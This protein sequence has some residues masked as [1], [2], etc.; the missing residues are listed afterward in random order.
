L[1]F[2]KVPVRINAAKN[3]TPAIRN[4]T[5]SPEGKRA[6]LVEPKEK[7]SAK[8]SPGRADFTN[9]ELGRKNQPAALEHKPEITT[10]AKPATSTS[11]HAL[12]R[13]RNAKS[14]ATIATMNM[15]SY[16]A[17]V[18]SAAKISSAVA[19]FPSGFSLSSIEAK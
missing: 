2:H 4:S 3:R 11:P 16:L 10:G 6:L 18:A 7:I 9:T 14:A 12:R 19:V 1:R 17:S 5:L 13:R 8:R 15:L